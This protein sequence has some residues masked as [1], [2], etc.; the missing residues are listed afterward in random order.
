MI[1]PKRKKSLGFACAFLIGT[2]MTIGVPHAEAASDVIATVGARSI[3]EAEIENQI[4]G[5]MLRLN[6]Q[7][8]SL[9]KQAADSIINNHLME[10]EAKKRNITRQE[11]LK[12]E[13]TAKTEQVTDKEVTDYYNKNKSRLG[14]KKLEEV[15]DQLKQS[16]Q[17]QKQ[18]QRQQAFNGE[19]RKAAKIDYKI[20]PPVVDVPIAGAPT[21]GPKNAPITLVE[22]SDYQ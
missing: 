20:A 21:K 19:L 11:L 13:V 8:Y 3:T 2:A 14:G 9:K 1:Q 12:Q 4:K 7:I 10:E 15:Q 22:F 6:N 5:Q 17:A 18:Q 16:L